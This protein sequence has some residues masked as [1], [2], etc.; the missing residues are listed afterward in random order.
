MFLDVD[1]KKV[2]WDGLPI[3]LTMLIEQN[4]DMCN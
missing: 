3:G 4:Y 2:E 1:A